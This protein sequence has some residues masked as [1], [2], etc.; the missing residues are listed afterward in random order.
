M[1]EEKKKEFWEFIKFVIIA[2][3]IVVPVRLW[4]AQ[5]FIVNGASMEPTYDNGDY[6]IV[7]EFSYHFRRPKKNE[8]IIFHYPLNP[9]EFF[10]KRVEGVPGETV[11][12]ENKE[13]K[14]KKGQYFVMGDNRT[15]SWDSRKWGPVPEKL[16]VGRVLV[17]LWPFNKIEILPGY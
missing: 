6:L 12:I 1:K 16:I 10:I 17:R 14:L 9:S 8:V 11:K 13:I 15:N 3:L 5:P 4:V 7:D 2:V